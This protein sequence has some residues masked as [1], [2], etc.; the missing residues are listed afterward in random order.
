M[1]TVAV[2]SK[3]GEKLMPT[4]AYRAR[5]LMKSGKAIA[6]KYRPVFTIQLVER[7]TGDIQ[8]IEY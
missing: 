5:K 1:N 8:P 6:Y 2:I 4:T 3:T 7:E